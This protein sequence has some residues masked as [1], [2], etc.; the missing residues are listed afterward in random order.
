[1]YELP[2]ILTNFVT[3]LL[4]PCSR[5]LSKKLTGPQL[6]NKFPSV[7]GTRNV[8]YCI[9]K[10]PPRFPIL[11]Q[12]NSVHASQFH[13]LKI[14]FNITLP[15]FLRSSKWSLSLRCTHQNLY[16]PLHY[17]IY[18]TCPGHLIRLALITRIIFDEEYDHETG[19]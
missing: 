3:Y 5:V 1:M 4:T 12:I 2:L 8:H 14:H 18:A 9:H 7:Y 13:F 16:A 15:L 6:V 19:C 17:P 10:R 11:S